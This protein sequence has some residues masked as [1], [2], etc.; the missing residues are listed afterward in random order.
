M[1]RV[2]DYGKNKTVM[3]YL[4]NMASGSS[5]K[6]DSGKEIA[7]AMRSALQNGISLEQFEKEQHAFIMEHTVGLQQ[8]LD[9]I[10][11][12]GLVKGVKDAY[13][14]DK[15]EQRKISVR[16][17]Q[18]NSVVKPKEKDVKKKGFVLKPKRTLVLKNTKDIEIGKDSR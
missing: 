4:E 13:E 11:L 12:D 2:V 17:K 7:L 5:S 9:L 15:C 1:I 16:P 8:K 10:C 14:R 3:A 6:L 18:I